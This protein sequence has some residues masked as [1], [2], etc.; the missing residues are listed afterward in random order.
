L[1]EVY[2]VKYFKYSLIALGF[3]YIANSYAEAQVVDATPI[4]PQQIQ[5]QAPVLS[6]EQR[7]AKLEQQLDN[8]QQFDLTSQISSLQ[9]AIQ[10]LRGQVDVLSHQQKQLE[11]RLNDF[12]QDL[13]KRV[14]EA[15]AKPRVALGAEVPIPAVK[16]RPVVK[17]AKVATK[18]HPAESVATVAPNDDSA[19]NFPLA[20]ED[21]AALDVS[22]TPVISQPLVEAVN[23]TTDAVQE[24][25]AYQTAYNAL[26]NRNYAQAT[27]AME[28]YLRNYPNG[29]YAASAYYWLGELYMV[30]GQADKA[31]SQFSTIIT[32]YP[33]D[34]KAADAT[35]KLGIVYYNKGQFPEAKQTFEQVTAKFAGT[36]AARLANARL[37]E[38]A[39]NGK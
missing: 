38:M 32:R 39:R 2:T 1:D 11:Q 26:K 33:R 17:S 24:Q 12:Y 21:K 13:S 14:D 18:L 15:K 36:A 19:D 28:S 16:P 37:Q 34:A 9:Q 31:A 27:P 25:N 7:V 20:Q 22:T 23:T 8:R 3:T 5:T 10:D 29:K 35:L 6:L 4:D 30:Q